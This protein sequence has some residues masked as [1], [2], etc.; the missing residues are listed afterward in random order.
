[1]EPTLATTKPTQQRL[2]KFK[3]APDKLPAREITDKGL[4]AISIIEQYRFI[5]TS[6]LVRL[7][8]GDK[9]NNYRHLQTLFHKGFV[10]RFALPRIGNPGEFIFYL[11]SVKSLQLLMSAGL[12]SP[13]DEEERKRRE[14][15]IRYNRE[16]DYAAMHRDTDSQGKMLYIQHELMVSR[17]HFLLSAACR[18]SDGQAELAE[19]KQGTELWQR[20]ECPKVVK[21]R[22]QELW[23]ETDGTESLPHR[24]DAFF[25]LKVRQPNGE[26]EL[27]SF[28]YEAD[29]T[30]E[31]A[32]R[33]QMKLRAHWHF[34]VKQNRHRLP[35]Y[36]TQNI[37]AVLIE[38]TDKTWASHIRE[39]ARHP[40]VSGKPSPLFWFTTSELLFTRPTPDQ[41]TKPLYLDQP[42]LI[43][44]KIWADPKEDKLLSLLS[45]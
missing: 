22:G 44:K 31:A 5:P 6:L 12:M 20:V 21:T 40:I 2:P 25:T 30:T 4:F 37:R 36:N 10:N 27:K 1:M 28:L 38:S 14:D 17:M 16:K 45:D 32:P 24:P 29:R 26:Y 15:I 8:P 43:F 42:E 39:A 13:A 41:P 11:D 33:M 35:P 34:C 9:K 19:W 18:K 3:R 23:Q 7:M